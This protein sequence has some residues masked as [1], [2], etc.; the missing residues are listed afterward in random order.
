M[1][2]SKGIPGLNDSDRSKDQ[3]THVDNSLT[4]ESNSS[5]NQTATVNNNPQIESGESSE[6]VH[7]EG[8]PETIISGLPTQKYGRKSWWCSRKTFVPDKNQ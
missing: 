8:L 2:T 5:P 7:K 3:I 6:V 4:P 1:Q